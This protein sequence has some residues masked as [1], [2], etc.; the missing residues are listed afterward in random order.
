MSEM[1][2]KIKDLAPDFTAP[3][4]SAGKNEAYDLTLSSLRGQS[5]VLYFYPKDDTPG[6]TTQACAL[7]D[8]WTEIS[9]KA[10]V[11]G[12]SVDSVKSHQKFITKHELPFILIS[13]EDKT[14]VQSYGVWV[15]KSLYGKKYLGTERTTF[16]ID[17]KGK[18]SA[19]FPKVKPADHFDLI[20]AAL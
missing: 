18:I 1:S 10:V 8:A 20:L 3:A 16:V 13:D 14:I 15:E 6:C 9:K 5:V 19:I 2:L 4:V 11:I 12:V 17:P 7:R